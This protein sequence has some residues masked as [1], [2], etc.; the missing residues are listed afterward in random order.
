[1]RTATRNALRATAIAASVTL[2]AWAI[3]PAFAQSNG[4]PGPQKAEQC[5]MMKGEQCPMHKRGYGIANP[6]EHVTKNL[7]E[8]GAN[9][10]LKDKQQG[11][12]KDYRDYLIQT[13]GDHQKQREGMR[14]QRG[15]MRD[16][17]APERLRKMADHMQKKADD[18]DK[19]AKKT[20]SF[21]G[22]LSPE[23]QTIFDLHQR[24]HHPHKMKHHRHGM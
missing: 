16:L 20:A 18:M 23:Q 14:E 19:L 3:Q 5:P 22:T 13:A 9:L 4:G 11:A 1:M 21:Y 17:P 8:L 12:W 7:D 6:V 15:T 24:K 10:H 2:G